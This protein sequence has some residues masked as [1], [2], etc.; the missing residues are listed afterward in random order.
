[1]RY[2]EDLTIHEI[3]HAINCSDNVVSVRIHR[4]IQKLKSHIAI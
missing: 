3:A 1:M 4:G 2:V